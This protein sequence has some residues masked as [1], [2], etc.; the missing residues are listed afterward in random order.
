MRQ[1]NV[2]LGNLVHLPHSFH[3]TIKAEAGVVHNGCCLL[4]ATYSMLLFPHSAAAAAAVDVM[5]VGPIPSALSRWL[6]IGFLDEDDKTLV[7][8]NRK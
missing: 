2:T 8:L 3:S 7:F 1:H 5:V 4:R 6:L